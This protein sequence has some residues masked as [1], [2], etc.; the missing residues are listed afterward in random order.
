MQQNE[1]FMNRCLQLAKLGVNHVAP[2][3]LVG[4]V[5]VHDGKVI[6]EGYHQKFG[7]NHA[8]VNA[9]EDVENKNLLSESTIYVSLEPC[10]HTGKTPPCAN[11]LVKHQFKKV[12]IGCRDS[13]DKVDGKGVQ[14]L[15]DAGIDVEIGVLE[16][17][18]LEINKHFFIYHS[19]KRP[20]VL[21]KW[22]ETK[23]GFIDSGDNDGS[24]TWI[25]SKET[26]SL[27]HL[28]R[29]SHQSILVGSN[30]VKN[31]N[32][33]LTTRLV[34]GPN[35]I[36][37]VIDANLKL[38]SSKKVYNS[39]AKT[40][41]INSVKNQIEKNI[42]WVK[43][44]EISPKNIL[45]NL[46]KRDIN[47]ILIEGGRITLQ[48]FIDAN[49]WDEAIRIIGKNSFKSGTKSPQMTGIPDEEFSYFEDKIIKYH[50]R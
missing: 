37:I 45:H 40:I 10:A 42:E 49:L 39:D 14:I 38:D 24:I 26:Q 41:I 19:K 28:L 34:D 43:L 5:I 50:N 6:G 35:P 22:A 44:D 46:Y 23:N 33:S 11:L 1:I 48:S 27:V 8:E 15:K 18:C 36:R 32:P 13:H 29:S 25:S 21:L 12:V 2:N 16:K 4:A 20:H 3:P 31:D 9:I 7:G 47:S 30:T 17:K